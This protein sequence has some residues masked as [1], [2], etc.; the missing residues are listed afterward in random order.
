[1]K[2]GYA[3]VPTTDQNLDLQLTALKDAGCGRFFGMVQKLLFLVNTSH[4]KKVT[5]GILIKG[6]WLFLKNIVFTTVL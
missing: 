5:I 3:R 6:L 4:F 1:M 2:I